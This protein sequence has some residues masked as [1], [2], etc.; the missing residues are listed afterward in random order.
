MKAF[1]ALGRTGG[2]TCVSL[3]LSSACR[4]EDGDS[5]PSC[6]PGTFDRDRV[7][8][9]ATGGTNTGGAGGAEA[10]VTGGTAGLAGG[11]GDASPPD[12][13]AQDGDAQD[14]DDLCPTTPVLLNCA[15]DC[16]GPS[17]ACSDPGVTC[18]KYPTT[19]SAK[20][21][22]AFPWV[23]RTPSHPGTDPDCAGLCSSGP[24]PAFGV[25]VDIGVPPDW[26]YDLRVTVAPPW[27]VFL[28]PFAEFCMTGSASGCVVGQGAAVSV[29]L[30][31]DDPNAPARNAL[32]E[33]VPKPATCQ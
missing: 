2:L 16:G 32:I 24:A 27:R 5:G 11:E 19:V 21:H 25:S 12:A 28:S 7:C 8:V 4:S 29:H 31:T 18:S 30:V 23:V 1:A 22:K 26:V 3:L 9:P 17:P 10:S 6:G 13:P 33:R 14:Q 20:E 15:S